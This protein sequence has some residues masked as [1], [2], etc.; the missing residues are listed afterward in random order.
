MSAKGLTR[1]LE[2]ENKK[3][4]KMFS[5]KKWTRLSALVMIVSMVLSACAA[6]TPEVIEK[7]VVVEKPV[8]E[9]VVVEKEVVVEKPVVETVVVEV[10]PEPTPTKVPTPTPVP[11]PKDKI[12]IGAARPISGPLKDVGDYAF[13]PIMQL[14]VND[15]NARGGIYVE[16]YGKS[17]PVEYIV[18]DDT[19]DLGT[20]IRL[21]EKLI[22][23]DEVDFLFPNCST[24]FLYASAPL[25]NKYG[26][27]Y[28]GSEGGCTTLTA[29]LPDLP[30]VFGVLN[31]SDYYQIPVLAEVFAEQ[32]VKTAAII[33][34]N[35]LHG[36]EYYH[37]SL[38]EFLKKGIN[39]VMAEAVP[40]FTEDVELVLKAARDSGA[41]ALCAFV[42]P[43]TSMAV[44]GQAMAIGYSPNAFVIGP[45]VNFQFFLDI[46]G[47]QVVEGLIG[48]GA[49]NR[50]TSPACNEL[51][52]KLVAA[53]GEVGMAAFGDEEAFLDWWGGALYWAG[54]QCLEQ[55]IGKAGTLD[56][57]VIRDVMA[58]EHFDT[59]LGDT[60]FDMT[61]GGEGGGLLA[62][63][64]HP[65]QVG[66]WQSGIYEVIGPA[67]KMTTDV[68][69]YPKPAWPAP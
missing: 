2:L 69:L 5:H 64:C 23:E 41:D 15:V 6:P 52:D 33:Y 38:S 10:T 22:L 27:V 11:P 13:G 65:G 68:I 60:W 26:Y 16:A 34:I 28:L 66:Q 14:W 29:M 17:L 55:A 62:K 43:P 12:L 48:F 1:F 54:L 51:A 20:S 25:A 44:V 7:E 56:Q 57:A 67:D 19:S 3:E 21:I 49:W 59:V 58:T 8:V 63:E 45:G 37:T 53:S 46:Y 24:A 32:G 40:A 47:P 9:T 18:Y 61:A 36:V 35:D 50:K 39:V 42:Y 30:Y 31:Y 4:E